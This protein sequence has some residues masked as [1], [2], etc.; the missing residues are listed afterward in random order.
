MDIRTKRVLV[1]LSPLVLIGIN[2]MVARVAGRV[3]GAWAFVPVV[4]IAWTISAFL[5]IWGGGADS[6]RKWLK[7]PSGSVGWG[8]LAISVAV[9]T[10][11]LFLMHWKLLISWTIFLPWILIALIN[12]WIEEFYWRGLLLDHTD[13]W[14]AWLSITFSSVVFAAN[15][16]LAFGVNSKAN[17]GITILVSTFIMGV[18]WAVVYRKTKSLRWAIFAHFLV[19]I[20]NLSVPAFLNMFQV[21]W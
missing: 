2:H 15:H 4:L 21:G 9:M 13:K 11:P 18:I 1:L 3:M 10:L 16:P 20:F 8:A 6:I 14:P 7:K 12:P 17:S 19:D 5:I